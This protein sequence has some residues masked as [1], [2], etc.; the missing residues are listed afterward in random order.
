MER[1]SIVRS[2]QPESVKNPGKQAM[3]ILEVV[4]HRICASIHS[5]CTG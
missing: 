4:F 5:K 2:Q 3:H 1:V